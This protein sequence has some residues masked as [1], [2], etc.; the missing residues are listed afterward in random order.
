MS[1]TLA[2]EASDVFSAI[3]SVAGTMSGYTWDNRNISEPM[4]ILQIHGLDDRVVPI[5]GS[6]S[7]EGGWGGAPHVDTIIEYWANLNNCTTSET[8]FIPPYTN[9]TY[10]IDHYNRILQLLLV[11]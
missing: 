7:E 8:E 10:Y 4:P 5:D 3:A 1:Y 11:L 6:I 2:C 9:A